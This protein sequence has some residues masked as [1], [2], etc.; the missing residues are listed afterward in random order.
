MKSSLFSKV[1]ATTADEKGT[2]LRF[3]SP[4]AL[5]CKEVSD[6]SQDGPRVRRLLIVPP[7][8]ST[9]HPRRFTEEIGKLCK[10]SA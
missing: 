3:N 10:K 1:K 2:L 6:I 4:Y 5:V 7:Y 8:E 9:A